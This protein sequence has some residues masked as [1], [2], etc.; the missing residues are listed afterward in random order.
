VLLE[1]VS[2]S[3]GS[4]GR[5]MRRHLADVSATGGLA[6]DVG[7]SQRK[8][9]GDVA[10]GRAGG[11]LRIP[12]ASGAFEYQEARAIHALRVTFLTPGCDVLELVRRGIVVGD[13]CPSLRRIPS[14]TFSHVGLVVRFISLWERKT[15][16]L[17]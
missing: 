2:D 11:P 8:E 15:G 3:F 10:R 16:F 9:H 12:A 5:T 6:V 1:G 13:G 17:S 7:L 4:R 14:Q